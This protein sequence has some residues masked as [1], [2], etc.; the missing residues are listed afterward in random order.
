MNKTKRGLMLAGSI[1]NVV[2]SGLNC[3]LLF[4]AL[5]LALAALSAATQWGDAADF[6]TIWSVINVFLSAALL[7][8]TLVISCFLMPSPDKTK[9]QRNYAK[10]LITL[11]VLNGLLLIF[12][13]ISLDILGIIFGVAILT[14]YIIALCIHKEDNNSQKKAKTQPNFVPMPGVQG[15]NQ[16]KSADNGN[17]NVP[18]NAQDYYF[19]CDLNDATD[20]KI[21]RAKQMFADGMIDEAELKDLLIQILSK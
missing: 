7:I 3:I 5:P 19:G 16:A 8:A 14:L 10:L 1:V 4:I 6:V 12:S 2:Y 21:F 15:V 13:F 17:K 20:R 9:K 18:Q 11:I